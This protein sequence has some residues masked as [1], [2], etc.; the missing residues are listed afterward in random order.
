MSVQRRK[1]NKG[2]V[3]KNG[4][5][6]R[7][8]GGYMYRYSN[9]YGARQC[10]YASDLKELR[11]KETEIRKALDCHIDYHAGKITLNEHIS[12]ALGCRM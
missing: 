5:S 10:I 3:L 7:K 12:T 4:E 6:Q 8:N 9:I 1:D 11:D 2:R